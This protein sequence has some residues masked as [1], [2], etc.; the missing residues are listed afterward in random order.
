[1]RGMLLNC[2]FGHLFFEVGFEVQKFLFGFQ[3][4]V[5][6]QRFGVFFGFFQSVCHT[7]FDGHVCDEPS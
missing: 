2:G 1:M 5:A 4:F 7:P 3:H 6:F